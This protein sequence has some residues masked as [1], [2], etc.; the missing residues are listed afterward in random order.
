MS[1]PMRG[2]DGDAGILAFTVN[3]PLDDWAQFKRR[4]QTEIA[5][6]GKYFHERMMADVG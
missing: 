6:I 4:H 1:F 3:L 5:F 2:P